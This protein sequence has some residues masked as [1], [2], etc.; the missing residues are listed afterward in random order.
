MIDYIAY[1]LYIIPALF[2][3]VIL[4]LAYDGLKQL[5]DVKRIITIWVVLSLIPLVNLCIMIYGIVHLTKYVM[6]DKR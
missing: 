3:F 4:Y 5:N 1:A 6:K 2:C